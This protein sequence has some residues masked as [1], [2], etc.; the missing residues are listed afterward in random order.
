MTPELPGCILPDGTRV[1][2][3]GF[4]TWH[5]GED[6][7]RRDAEVAAIR[8]ALD[9][10]MTLVDTAEMYGSGGAEEA[11]GDAIRDRRE[12]V[13]VVSKFYPHH[14]S[15][16]LLRRACEASR[17]RLGIETIDLYLYHW[18]GNVPLAET[19]DALGELVDEGRI[20]RWGVSNFDV[21]DLEELV[22]IPGGERVAANQV[23]YN[24]ARRGPEFDLLPWC[25]T[26]GIPLMAYSPL[27]EGRLLR[28]HGFAALA[29]ELGA[30]PA[31]LA[32]AWL[33][34]H[35]DVIAIPKAARA[36]HARDNRAAVQRT[37]DAAA[38]ARIDAMFPPPRRKLALE[39]I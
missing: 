24:P 29:G 27:D 6:A 38:L 32:L 12:D 37:L 7:S 22:A 1:P 8:L 39:M 4:G 19:V 11:V 17:A 34:R 28:H 33:L 15:R 31:Q 30:S 10:G 25:R 23:L 16:P 9:L 18:R 13:F 5:L 26:R 35:D 36:P 3:L 14:A 20:R 21:A 2:R